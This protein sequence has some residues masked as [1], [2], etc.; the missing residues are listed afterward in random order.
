MDVSLHVANYWDHCQRVVAGLPE[1][2]PEVW[3]FGATPGQAD[4]LLALVLAGGKTATSSS[5]WD[6]EHSGDAL[7]AAGAL[8]IILDG[9][10][11]PRAL[12]ETTAVEVVSF[13]EVSQAHA[14]AEG[15]G[16]RTLS[17]WRAVH[18]KYWREHSESPLGFAPDMPVI[19]EQFRVIL[20]GGS[21]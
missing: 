13:G 8:S 4:R 21:A 5:L 17:H 6:Y 3:A 9:Q 11:Q 20:G 10:Q 7:P 1:E 12:I 16:D 14:A 15:E 19:C 2:T 18:E